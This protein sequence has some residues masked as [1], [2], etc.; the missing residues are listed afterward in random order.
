[1]NKVV[2]RYYWKGIY[3]DV[4]YW[5]KHFEACQRSKQ[6]FDKPAALLHLIPVSDTWHKVGIDLIE[7]PLTPRGNRY[8]I[9][10][11]DYFSK[12]AEAAPIPTKASCVAKFLHKMIL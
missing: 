12:W 8:C 1:M 3:G 4:D 9:T 2:A 5:V 6:K 7:L 10:L 11:T